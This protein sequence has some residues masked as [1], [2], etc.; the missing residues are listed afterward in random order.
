A[1]YVAFDCEQ[2]TTPLIARLAR[3]DRDVGADRVEIDISDGTRTFAFW[4]NAAGVLGDG[5]RFN[6]TDYS[7]DWDGVWDAQVRQRAD[8]WSAEMRIPLSFFRLDAGA[9]Q[10]WGLQARRYLPARRETDEWAYTPRTVA[11]EISHYGRLTGLAGL[12][13]GNPIELR[14]F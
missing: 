14:P 3:R 11:G 5:I 10:D 6:D 13:P 12:R 4:V 2:R 8:G 9:V 1:L 7:A